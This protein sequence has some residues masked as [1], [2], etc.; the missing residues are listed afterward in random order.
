V[1]ESFEPALAGV[2]YA[3]RSVDECQR[4]KLRVIRRHGRYPDRRV[5]RRGVVRAH[6]GTPSCAERNPEAV[7]GQV[8]VVEGEEIA[9]VRLE[10]VVRR[11]QE[12]IPG[13]P[14]RGGRTAPLLPEGCCLSD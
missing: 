9:Q 12:I 6:L 5:L 10:A 11:R 8:L 3:A 7:R 13:V 14:D 4:R 1:R 2:A